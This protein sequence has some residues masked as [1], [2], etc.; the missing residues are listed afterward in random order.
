MHI[1]KPLPPQWANRKS[2]SAAEYRDWLAG[3]IQPEIKSASPFP[4]GTGGRRADLDNRYFRSMMEAN[5]ARYYNFVGIKWEYEPREFKFPIERGIRFYKPDFYLPDTD[6]YIECKG[7]F[8]PK[9]K[10]RMKRMAK[11]FPEV[12]VHIMDWVE[13]KALAKQ[14][15]MLIPGWEYGKSED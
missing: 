8:D 12:K 1:N 6:T 10:T 9:S 11:Y 4:K 5:V 2:I 3:K 15:S 7:W 14:V 13:Y